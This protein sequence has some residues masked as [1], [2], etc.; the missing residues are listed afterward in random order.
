MGTY[1]QS[2]ALGGALACPLL[3]TDV[4][5]SIPTGGNSPKT[6]D[7]VRHSVAA[8]HSCLFTSVAYLC[9]GLTNEVELKTAGRKLREVCAEAVLADPDPATRAL[10][11]GHD[12]VEA[13]VQWIRNETHWGG[14]P[15]VLM[16]AEHFET[17]LVVVSCE[18]LSTLPYGDGTN[19]TAYLLY[20]GQHY[21][22]LPNAAAADGAPHRCFAP[23]GGGDGDEA[24]ARDKA[25][26][27][28]AQQHNI[29]AAR[30]AKERRV[31]RLKCSGC[32]ALCDDA[33]AFQA[34]PRREAA[35]PCHHR[36]VRAHPPLGTAPPASLP[37]SARRT[38]ARWS[39]TTTSRTTASRWR[40]SSG[41]MTRCPRAMS[42]CALACRSKAA[43]THSHAIGTHRPRA[44]H[45][46]PLTRVLSAQQRAG[47]ARL[48]QRRRRRDP[49]VLDALRRRTL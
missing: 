37:R 42:I 38:A 33:A 14:E 6:M 4:T 39:T 11:L 23:A 46:L 5:V 35:G 24:A 10:M 19:G 43:R 18:S 41:P 22:P 30:R 8:D 32:G 26:I 44:Q 49:L 16:L 1:R 45:A 15:E 2:V 47:R 3:I 21:D 25:A 27:G 34:S 28:L 40:W 36:L 31:Q 20:T 9:Q 13:Y 17:R 29:E 7:I 48:L 12:S